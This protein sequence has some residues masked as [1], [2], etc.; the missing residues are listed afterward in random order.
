MPCPRYWC[1][2][3]RVARSCLAATIFA[4]SCLQAAAIASHTAPMGA[5]LHL[6]APFR[7]PAI[8]SIR[9]QS[10]ETSQGNDGR[11]SGA[12]SHSW[13]SHAGLWR[14]RK[15]GR[16]ELRAKKKDAQ[17][18]D[19]EQPVRQIDDP[20]VAEVAARME[21][22]KSNWE[23]DGL[24]WPADVYPQ[25]VPAFTAKVATGVLGQ[26]L[27]GSN[28]LHTVL[29][30][31]ARRLR[32]E[33]NTELEVLAV[34]SHGRRGEDK[35]LLSFKPMSL[36]EIE[37]RWVGEAIPLD[38][39]EFARHISDTREAG[40]E[41]RLI[42]DLTGSLGEKVGEPGM[43]DR[44]ADLYEQWGPRPPPSPRTNW[45]RLVLPPVL[46]GHVSSFPPLLYEQC[47]RGSIS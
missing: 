29:G 1:R 17:E 19:K 16:L 24:D 26:A 39:G 43:W 38:L 15:A 37:A 45:T 4:L 47:P 42:L 21:E 36:E 27:V 12:V 30:E 7:L 10:S 31:E 28:L 11:C 20:A 5:F 2:G 18:K 46:S 22:F 6:P 35:M 33:F 44:L 41:H 13:L 23:P 32:E 34:A 3:R 40:G 14:E 25:A 9:R 8:P